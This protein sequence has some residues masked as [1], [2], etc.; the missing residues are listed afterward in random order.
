MSHGFR[1][2]SLQAVGGA[3]HQALATAPAATRLRCEGG[4]NAMVRLPDTRSS[5]EWAIGLL[6]QQGVLV[7]P[8][9]FYDLGAALSPDASVVLSLLCEAEPFALGAS[10]LAGALAGASGLG[11]AS[12]VGATARG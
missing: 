4:W 11:G 7:Q 2:V 10:A 5:E 8:G 6:E 3:R 12:G 1:Q 9:Y